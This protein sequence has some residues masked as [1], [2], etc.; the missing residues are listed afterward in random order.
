MSEF[1]KRIQILNKKK[2]CV[3]VCAGGGGGG[4][5]WGLELVKFLRR[6]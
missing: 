5:E 4:A 3:C 6:I 1:F 2:L